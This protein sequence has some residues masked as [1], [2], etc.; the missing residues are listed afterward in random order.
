LSSDI[1]RHLPLVCA[2]CGAQTI[3]AGSSVEDADCA[4]LERYASENGTTMCLDRIPQ[5]VVDR[6][7]QAVFDD[8]SAS[9]SGAGVSTED[10][11]F[12]LSRLQL[13]SRENT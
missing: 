2:R 8:I 11:E 7:V 1:G 12:V 3:I 10:A 5:E 4:A 9:L 13:F 6:A